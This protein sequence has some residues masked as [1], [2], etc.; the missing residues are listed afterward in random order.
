MDTIIDSEHRKSKDKTDNDKS[1]ES[2]DDNDQI[3]LIN[4]NGTQAEPTGS[5][6]D[7]EFYVFFNS[8]RDTIF[9]IDA[10]IKKTSR[11]T[12]N[13]N[14]THMQVNTPV[15]IEALNQSIS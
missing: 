5:F 10:Y 11:Y 15:L 12:K 9:R 4:Q 13:K 6:E 2:S 7:C 14:G 8:L 3:T 1:N